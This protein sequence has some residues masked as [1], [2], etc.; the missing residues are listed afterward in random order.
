MLVDMGSL[1]ISNIKLEDVHWVYESLADILSLTSHDT[2]ST[3]LSFRPLHSGKQTPLPLEK[4]DGNLIKNIL[5]TKKINYTIHPIMEIHWIIAK[6]NTRQLIQ[7]FIRMRKFD[8]WTLSKLNLE[9][10]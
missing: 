8:I 9:H 10:K 4:R 3:H 6:I 7:L 5:F 2:F 1:E